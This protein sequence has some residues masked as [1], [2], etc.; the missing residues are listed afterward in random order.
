V[1]P[2]ALGAF[3]TAH[4]KELL[5]GGA[6]VAVVGGLYARSKS[7]AASTTATTAANPGTTAP[8]PPRPSTGAS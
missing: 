5:A 6:G 1:N 7:T 3:A 8:T 4:K 2:G